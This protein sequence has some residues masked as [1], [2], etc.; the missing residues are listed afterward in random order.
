MSSKKD[1]QDQLAEASQNF[2]SPSLRHPTGGGNTFTERP[3]KRSVLE[4]PRHNAQAPAEK[5]PKNEDL[6]NAVKGITLT[7]TSGGDESW[8]EASIRGSNRLTL[9]SATQRPPQPESSRAQACTNPLPSDRLKRASDALDAHAR[10][11]N[12]WRNVAMQLSR[13]ALEVGSPRYS[14]PPD[15][16]DN[17][18]YIFVTALR[19]WL[20]LPEQSINKQRNMIM[21]D[22]LMQRDVFARLKGRE[23]VSVS[24][25]SMHK[26]FLHEK[27]KTDLGLVIVHCY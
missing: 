11:A 17:E 19:S 1:K 5:K 7:T 12:Y 13:P 6:T 2:A 24:Q 3:L 4:E 15:P 20:S 16:T 9:C 8:Q 18:L 25:H 14:R 10:A 23:D 21:G 22:Y 26:E 27:Y